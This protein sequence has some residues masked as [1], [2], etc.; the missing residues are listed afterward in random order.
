MVLHYC[1]RE[2]VM[3]KKNE[4]G[5]V[6]VMTLLLLSIITVLTMVMLERTIL[7]LK[8]AD[9]FAKVS[10]ESHKVYS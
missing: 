5:I 1:R 8:V 3:F 9:N 7:C 10:L 4:Q 2:K 6:L